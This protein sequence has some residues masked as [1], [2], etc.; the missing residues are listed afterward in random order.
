MRLGHVGQK[1][2]SD[3]CRFRFRLHA[4]ATQKMQ[5]LNESQNAFELNLS[6]GSSVFGVA[7][8]QRNR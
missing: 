3:G 7:E 5:K 8:C 1:K 4:A 2:S 6:E